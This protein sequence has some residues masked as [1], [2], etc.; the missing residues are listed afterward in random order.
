MRA[1][2]PGLTDPGRLALKSAARAAIVM[3]A[4]FAFADKVIQ[5]P[6]TTI[7]AALGSF[8]ILVLA[9]L[10]GPADRRLVAYLALF[11]A[12]AVFITLGTLCSTDPWLGAGAMA[13]VAFGIL[14]SSAINGYFAAA[15][16]AALLTFILPVNVPAEPSAIPP[17][18]EGWALACGVG[19]T[20]LMLLWPPRSRDTL[21]EAAARACRALA[22]LVAAELA[23]DPSLVSGCDRA[24]RAEVAAVRREF[25]STPHRPTGATGSTE[26]LA[27]LVDELDWFL[28]IAHVPADGTGSAAGLCAAENREVMAAVAAA[29]RGSAATLD[30]GDERPDLDRLDRTR[31]A[32][33]DALARDVARRPAEPGDL[34]L[35]SRMDPS[36][37]MREMSFVA[38]DVGR[39]AQRAAGRGAPGRRAAR[40]RSALRA[41]RRLVRAHASARSA[42]LRNSVRGAAALAIAVAIAQQAGFQNA[43]WVVLGTLSVLRSNALG[44][45]SSVLSA[46][47]GTALGLLVGVGVVIAAG[48]DQTVLW[49]LLPVAVLLAAYAPRAISFA[50]GQA[51]FTLTLLILFNLI[52]PSGWTVGL[53]RVED[54]AAGFAVSLGV[55]ALFWPRG[56]ATVVRRGL[57]DSYVRGADYVAAA[58]ERL[59]GGGDANRIAGARREARAAADRL[60]DA[61]R[62]YLAEDSADRGHRED[63]AKLVAGATRVRL[64]AYSLSTLAPPPDG[65]GPGRSVDALDGEV[66]RLRSWYSALGDALLEARPAPPPRHRDM[67]GRLRVLRCAHE[68]VAR[69]DAAGVGLGLGLLW[70]GQQLDDLRRLE[71]QLVAPAG[72]LAG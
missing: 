47:A 9:D 59:A 18:L 6:Q 28:S 55:G 62:Q 29:L 23:G 49:A 16:F 7:F 65:S 31:A 60:D 39:N 27:F 37:R 11:T 4:V 66:R 48:T 20:A 56:A 46:L 41:A 50:A 45:G 57:A 52:Q 44:T 30:G 2:W 12:G 51:G 43:F 40:A 35:L 64:G 68:A 22:D 13:V 17:R 19:I 54:I 24:A 38:R 1:L 14:F 70:A 21:R 25:V 71:S 8:A 32:V 34:T 10:R 58:V 36:F 69:E 67:D 72:E 63:L 15:G 53:V 5:Q 33:A 26:A 61:F 42:L 3:P